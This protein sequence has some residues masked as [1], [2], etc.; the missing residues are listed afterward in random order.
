[1][2]L[3]KIKTADLRKMAEKQKIEGWEDMERDAL[4]EALKPKEKP[5]ET[6][7]APAEGGEEEVNL[8]KLTAKELKEMAKE[9]G[10]SVKGLRKRDDMIKAIE[11]G[12]KEKDPEAPPETPEEGD[13]EA[14]P[15]L[16]AGI[17][18]EHIPKG[19]KAERML[20]HLAKQRKIRIVIPLEGK[21]KPGLT[22]PVTINGLR[23]NIVKGV[24]VE[25]PEQIA[26]AI[27]KSQ[28]QTMEA[29][30]PSLNLGNPNHPKKK[31]GEGLEDIDA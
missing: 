10:I 22:V 26:D 29:L 13:P 1:M 3:D 2:N 11:G 14:L 30:N 8:S 25:V 6:P 21:E 9:K 24:Y 20:R 17:K 31:S 27:M 18:K 5:E 28:K 4:L 16:G 12:K 19:S 23:L 7:E 15:S